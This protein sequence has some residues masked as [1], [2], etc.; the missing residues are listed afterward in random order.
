M[1][2]A[3]AHECGF[4]DTHGALAPVKPTTWAELVLQPPCF[5][6]SFQI[7]LSYRSS[8]LSGEALVKDAF[9]FQVSL[10]LGP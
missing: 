7:F 9:A 5:V 8:F 4:N 3:G 1:E 10:T 6:F 2:G